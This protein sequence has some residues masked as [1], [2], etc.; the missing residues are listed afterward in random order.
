MAKKVSLKNAVT[1]LYWLEHYTQEFVDELNTV[2]YMIKREEQKDEANSK[3]LIQLKKDRRKA[4]KNIN[5][6]Y[7]FK[8]ITIDKLVASQELIIQTVGEKIWSGDSFYL[9]TTFKTVNGLKFMQPEQPQDVLIIERSMPIEAEIGIN[10]YT[11]E[12]QY[13]YKKVIRTLTD[14]NK[15][16]PAMLNYISMPIVT[17]HNKL[18]STKGD[19]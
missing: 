6:C 13:P 17:K 1:A 7:R 16:N 12:G 5:F 9:M 3:H 18:S 2:K 11:D 8:K 19:T 14:Y 15:I 4:S 10:D